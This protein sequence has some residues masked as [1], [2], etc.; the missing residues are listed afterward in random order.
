MNSKC[1]Y[2]SAK[3]Q[4]NPIVLQV[5]PQPCVNIPP[6]EHV[7]PLDILLSVCMVLSHQLVHNS[8]VRQ[9]KQLL[10]SLSSYQKME[11]LRPV[12]GYR[13]N[14]NIGQQLSKS[15][16]LPGSHAFSLQP[17]YT[18]TC[19]HRHTHSRCSKRP[20]CQLELLLILGA[21][22]CSWPAPYAVSSSAS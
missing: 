5:F 14:D 21:K 7:P 1:I 15:R 17:I 12:Q 13:G 22:I 16:I 6:G 9:I 8:S 10:G 18:C 2:C 3:G 19:T 20:T 11:R 4:H